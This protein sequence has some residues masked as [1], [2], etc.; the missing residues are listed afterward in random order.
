MTE[1]TATR[2]FQRASSPT[3]T[4]SITPTPKDRG[5]SSRRQ[6]AIVVS[7]NWVDPALRTRL[8]T[9]M[10][11]PHNEHQDASLLADQL[12]SDDIDWNVVRNT[13]RRN[14]L[15]ALL[16]ELSHGFNSLHQ[17]CRKTAPLSVVKLIVRQRPDAIRKNDINGC[18]PLHIASGSQQSLEVVQFLVQEHPHALKRKENKGKLPLHIACAYEATLEVI[19]LLIREYPGAIKVKDNKGNLPLHAACAM[20][21][22]LEVIQF[23]VRQHPQALKEKSSLDFLPLHL[24]CGFQQSL[25]VIQFLIQQLR[26]TVREKDK[27]GNL[28]LHAACQGQQPVKVIRL[29]VQQHPHALKVKNEDGNLPLH[30]ACE[31]KQSLGVI[32]LLV[33]QH[34]HALKEKNHNGKT[35][36]DLAKWT[37]NGRNSDPKTVKWLEAVRSGQIILPKL[38]R[39]PPRRDEG[40]TDGSCPPPAVVE[41]DLAKLPT[42]DS[43][44][45]V[46]AMDRCS[47]LAV[48]VE[49]KEMAAVSPSY[50]ESIRT[51]EILR[52]GFFGS[53]YKGADAELR[54]SF[55]IKAINTELLW[56]GNSADVQKAEESF[57]E[58]IKVR[59][60]PLCTFSTRLFASTRAL[61]GLPSHFFLL[62]DIF[63]LSSSKH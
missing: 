2:Q 34:Q 54:R 3:T 59:H 38:P 55:A 57:L 45:D 31:L 29:L 39:A 56:G 49:E 26:D 36:L 7:T 16:L 37:G 52:N 21:Q 20:K 11:A 12:L 30:N 61:C 8:A 47:V 41:K 32:Q 22:S 58:E 50:I 42:A 53:V 40:N 18:L 13:L 23:L 27:F 48:L 5:G 43:N 33:Q 46:I 10:N 14:P 25:E 63:A 51:K 1:C 24:A 44:D 62:K 9:R 4:R 15:A 28:P 17:A 60:S 6:R 35:P 19:Q